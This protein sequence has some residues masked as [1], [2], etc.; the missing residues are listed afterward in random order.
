MAKAKKYKL[1]VP[2]AGLPAGAVVSGPAVDVLVANGKAAEM[3]D[4]T[5]TIPAK[6]MKEGE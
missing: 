2:A 3:V 5:D 1:L 4:T 6:K